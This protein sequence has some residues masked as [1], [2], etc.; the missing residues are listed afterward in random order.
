MIRIKSFYLLGILFIT[1]IF[2]SSGCKFYEFF[3]SDKKQI[4]RQIERIKAGINN[5][6]WT[7]VKS[8][9][10]EDFKW[11]SSDK[12]TYKTKRKGRKKKE[13]GKIFFQ[14]SIDKLPR[15]RIAFFM[16]VT[17]LKKVTSDRYIITVS[18]RLKIRKGAADNDNIKWTSLHTWTKIGDKWKVASIKD[19]TQK[20]GNR[21]LHYHTNPVLNRI[22]KSKRRR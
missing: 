1:S 4:K 16:N 14:A 15:D 9:M 19:I 21:D 6:N 3:K 10:V 18:S 13:F 20:I 7:L 22:S 12:V 17:E 11:I 2:I 5:D 8:L